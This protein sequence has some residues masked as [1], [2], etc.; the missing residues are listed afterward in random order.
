M[1]TIPAGDPSGLV[2]INARPL[3]G[4]QRTAEFSPSPLRQLPRGLVQTPRAAGV[5]FAS[6]TSCS[7]R[8]QNL[9]RSRDRP[10]RADK[11]RQRLRLSAAQRQNIRDPRLAE[12][13]ES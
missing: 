7:R 2:T 9:Q 13:R 6:C 12:T 10:A 11:R 5:A 8:R 4:D 3:F 1:S